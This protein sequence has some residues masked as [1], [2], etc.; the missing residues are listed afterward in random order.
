M[1]L[2][3][4]KHS[5]DCSPSFCFKMV[6]GYFMWPKLPS[7]VCKYFRLFL[8]SARRFLNII[9]HAIG[10]KFGKYIET[11]GVRVNKKRLKQL[12]LSSSSFETFERVNQNLKMASQ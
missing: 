7:K 3:L 1:R 10:F 8:L 2:K 9:L 11:N 4:G 5:N 6:D 12:L